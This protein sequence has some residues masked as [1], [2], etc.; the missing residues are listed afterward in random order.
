MGKL[1]YGALASLDGFV[2]DGQ[3]NFDWAEPKEDVHSYINGLEEQNQAI[4]LGRKLYEIMTFWESEDALRGF[5]AYI[6]DY[7]RI[8]RKAE[9][10]VF[11]RTL[12]SVGGSRTT[13]RSA[14][15]AEEIRKMKETTA[16][17]IGIGGS[18]LAGVAM[19]HGLVDELYLFVFPVI[20]GDGKPAI[21]RGAGMSLSLAETKRFEGGVVLLRYEV[22]RGGQHGS[23]R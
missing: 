22:E 12:K 19:S 23:D 14:F 16:G 13:I 15:E 21:S 4:L 3:G 11:S 8:W 5:P 18:E 9:K 1:I 6:Q 17:N 2:A 20:V 10:I 7:G